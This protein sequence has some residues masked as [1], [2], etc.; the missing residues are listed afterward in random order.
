[1]KFK[2]DSMH[3]LFAVGEK[4][5]EFEFI[6]EMKMNS[7]IIKK[8]L[9]MKI[10]I[11]YLNLFYINSSIKQDMK[12][13]FRLICVCMSECECAVLRLLMILKSKWSLF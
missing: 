6:H 10:H 5:C 3:Q 2:F 13:Y 4:Y 7:I 8:K 11:F 12:L 1:M 9:T